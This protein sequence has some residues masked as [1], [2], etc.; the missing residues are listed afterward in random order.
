MPA[1][2][3]ARLVAPQR[4]GCGILPHAA[5]RPRTGDFS[6]PNSRGSRGILRL[7]FFMD[8][9]GPESPPRARSNSIPLRAGQHSRF[10]RLRQWFRLPLP[11]SQRL[12]SLDGAH[13]SATVSRNLQDLW[14]LHVPRIRCR[15]ALQHSLLNADLHSALPHRP[16]SRRP[17]N[18]SRR[19]MDLGIFP[20]RDSHP[21]RMY[22]GRLTSGPT[23]GRN[24]MGHA[25]AR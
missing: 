3:P 23:R 21:V 7:G 9:A 4:I 15:N 20:E 13:L 24:S 8:Y 10:D 5:T 25:R 18:R 6:A 17:L 12:D 14:L 22:V 11:S 1:D 16:T 19:R 2:S